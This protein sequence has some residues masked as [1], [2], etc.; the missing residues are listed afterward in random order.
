VPDDLYTHRDE[1][2]VIVTE[3]GCGNVSFY[4]T[5][6]GRIS[7]KVL[8]ADGQP[9]PKILLYLMRAED[10][11][12]KSPQWNYA[13]ADEEGRFTF[14]PLLPGRYLLG[15]RLNGLTSPGDV[16]NGYPPTFYPG[17]SDV[18]Q[19][20][21]INVSRPGEHV[22]DHVLQL[23]PRLTERMVEGVVMF[24][25]NRPA[26]KV[27]VSYQELSDNNLATSYGLES[28]DQGRFKIKIYDGFTYLV[29][30]H[31]NTGKGSEQ[32]HA[33]PVEV[34]AS[35]ELKP[36]QL[37]ISEPNGSCQRCRD[38]RFGKRRTQP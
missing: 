3:R 29:S 36:I 24:P 10:V 2:K 12:A 25:D 19:A 20:T 13:A 1:E 38:R 5:D 7:G 15:V 17:V 27:L 4:L 33:E 14:Q 22:S 8:D 23:P 18:A 30:A 6:N 34:T 31:V 21:P 37:T 26:A 35:P 28:D 11:G 32:M 16:G 9:V